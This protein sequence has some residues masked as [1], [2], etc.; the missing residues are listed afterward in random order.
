MQMTWSNRKQEQ[1]YLSQL[2]EMLV[3]RIRTQPTAE[4]E[5]AAARLREDEELS[6]L[7]REINEELCR[8]EQLV[9]GIDDL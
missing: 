9:S 1:S 8:I 4:M 6:E 7:S 3:K 5:I 2:E